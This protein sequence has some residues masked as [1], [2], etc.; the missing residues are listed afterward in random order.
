MSRSMDTTGTLW[1]ARYTVEDVL[2][3]LMNG[4]NLSLWLDA[5]NIDGNHNNTLVDGTSVTSW[6][7]VRNSGRYLSTSSMTGSVS[8]NASNKSVEFN[9][10]GMSS[11]DFVDAQTFPCS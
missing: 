5:K 4:G 10:R 1:E 8:F 7:D 9:A 2:G 3:N 11:N 6:M